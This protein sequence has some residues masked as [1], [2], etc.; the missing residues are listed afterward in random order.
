MVNMT[1]K[2]WRTCLVLWMVAWLPLSGA[3]AAV[4]PVQALAPVQSTAP[5]ATDEAISTSMPCHAAQ[6]DDT[7]PASG[8]CT[9]CEL[10]HLANALIASPFMHIDAGTPQAFEFIWP[11]LTFMSHIPELPQ[12]PP[13]L[14][15]D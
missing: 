15:L 3:F 12:R 9:H 14:S 5:G 2:P 4:M 10:C 1:M 11:P 7:V 8:A 13:S 6:A